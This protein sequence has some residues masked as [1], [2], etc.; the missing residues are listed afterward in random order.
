[1]E[2]VFQDPNR[3]RKIKGII[4]ITVV[5]LILLLVVGLLL[6]F[7][8]KGRREKQEEMELAFTNVETYIEDSNYIRAK[9]ECDKAL[10]LAGELKDK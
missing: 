7:W 4:R 3:K 8:Q 6:F 10:K 2:K 5:V 1:M 9:E